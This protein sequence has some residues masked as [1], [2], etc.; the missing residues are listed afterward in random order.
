ME[1][2]PKQDK[3]S[4]NKHEIYI[5]HPRSLPQTKKAKAKQKKHQ[6]NETKPKNNHPQQEPLTSQEKHYS[7]I[8]TREPQSISQKDRDLKQTQ[9]KSFIFL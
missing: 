1:P 3:V 7:L 8:Y 5:T 6:N 9:P 4:P 2:E